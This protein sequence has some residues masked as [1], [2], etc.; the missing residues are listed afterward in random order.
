MNDDIEALFS[1]FGDWLVHDGPDP[2]YF[3][4]F[5]IALLVAMLALVIA[6]WTAPS[7]KLWVKEK[8]K[9][10][11]RRRRKQRKSMKSL[12]RTGGFG[13]IRQQWKTQIRLLVSLLDKRVVIV[14]VLLFALV[15]AM[16][17][18]L[19]KFEN[20][21]DQRAEDTR[22]IVADL[23]ALFDEKENEL[24]QITTTRT[25]Y[26]SRC[27][28]IAS[29]DGRKDAED[30]CR[31]R[32]KSRTSAKDDVQ[33]MANSYEKCM[34]EFG[35]FVQKC[36][37]DDPDPKCRNII[38]R[39]DHCEIAL[40]R[41]V[42]VY[43]GEECRWVEGEQIRRINAE[44]RCLSESYRYQM[45]KWYEGY[46][47][48]DRLNGT[49]WTYKECMY[50]EGWNTTAC[51]AESNEKQKCQEIPFNTSLCQDRTRRWL[52]GEINRQPCQQAEGWLFRSRQ[53]PTNRQW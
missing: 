23:L 20:R 24:F 18:A 29:E 46:T 39:T 33:L 28:F 47:D 12:K 9:K 2:L 53:E 6:Q 21:D 44:Y 36:D 3:G 32:L 14:S 25:T 5:Y 38:D 34:M 45:E 30:H 7:R 8:I 13:N 42:D 35:W 16:A 22:L 1:S 31:T 48:L 26:A 37:C 51:G 10:I 4:Q 52:S 11:K 17:I 19:I 41:T 40:W 49:I 50:K 27:D 43:I 15:I